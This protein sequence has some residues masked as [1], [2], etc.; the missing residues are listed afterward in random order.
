M[1]KATTARFAEFVFEVE[2]VASSGVYTR[3]CGMTDV[4]FTRAANV[5][6]TEVPDCDDESKPYEIEKEVRSL[7][8]TVSG[9][10]VWAR[11][12]HEAILDW[13]YSGRSKLARIGH[14][15]AGSGDTIYEG[16]PCLLTSVN[17]ARTKGQKVTAA[18]EF[19]F[20]GFDA[21]AFSGSTLAPWDGG[22]PV[23]DFA[24]LPNSI[25]VA[26]TVE[27]DEAI[28]K[29]GAASFKAAG[30]GYMT[31]PDAS[32]RLIFSDDDFTIEMWVRSTDEE[33]IS[34]CGL[35]SQWGGSGNKSQTFL[36]DQ[37]TSR[38]TWYGSIDGSAETWVAYWDLGDD[39]PGTSVSEFFALGWHHVAAQRRAGVVTVYVDGVAGSVTASIGSSA[40]FEGSSQAQL[41]GARYSV[42]L[43]PRQ[44]WK[45][46]IDEVRVSIGRARYTGDF[47][48]R[49]KAFPRS[50][51][52]DPYFST[53]KLLCDF[54]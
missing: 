4:Q 31:I 49:S 15:A 14:L 18:L 17:N 10:G 11:E 29:Y 23:P 45:G 13:F 27:K 2:W 51:Q 37:G 12:S 48:P 43:V 54:E 39:M 21:S 9:S 16:G 24:A 1:A 42:D 30:L 38:F 22:S 44:P 50:I 8:L 40:I 36:F 46:N 7:E 32:S 53:V 19:A 20:S 52:G 47:T 6:S 35:Y 5:D 41:I 3:I 26:G 28:F 33:P 34:I 25:S